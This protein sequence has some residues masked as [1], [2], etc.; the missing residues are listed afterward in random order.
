METLRTKILGFALLLAGIALCGTGLWLLLSPAQYQATV[1]IKLEM[2]WGEMEDYFKAHPESRPTAIYD[3]YSAQPT[4]ETIKSQSFLSNVVLTLNLNEAWSKKYGDGSPLKTERA[5]ELLKRRMTLRSVWNTQLI[6]ISFRSEDPNEAARIAN[7][8]ANAYRD[9]RMKLHQQLAT[10]GLQV[11]EQS[12]QKDEEKIRV[13]QTNVDVLREKYKINK[14]DETDFDNG[15]TTLSNS[16]FWTPAQQEEFQ[17]EYE[18]N[19]P[20]WDEKRKLNEMIEF[21]NLLHA[22]IESEKLDLLV[23]KT[24][25]VEIIDDAAQPPKFPAS[26]NRWFGSALLAAGLLPTLGGLL[27]LKSTFRRAD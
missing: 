22:K 21:H 26:P 8:I 7:A 25:T 1:R 20:F 14:D 10:N 15:G 3:W 2:D 18:T 16:K 17:K 9:Y 5:I 24:A 19:K 11:L 23:P 13:L 27:L 6:E 4:F 12:Y